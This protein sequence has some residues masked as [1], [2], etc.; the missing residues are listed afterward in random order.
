MSEKTVTLNYD[1]GSIV[2]TLNKCLHCGKQSTAEDAEKAL[3]RDRD[4]IRSCAVCRVKPPSV[5]SARLYHSADSD[6][7][8]RRHGWILCGTGIPIDP[9]WNTEWVSVSSYGPGGT[10]N[11]VFHAECLKRV[12]PGVRIDPR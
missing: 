10:V 9:N 8:Q 4:T 2:I 5:P 12:A 6:D 7:D 3:K 11:A 1:C